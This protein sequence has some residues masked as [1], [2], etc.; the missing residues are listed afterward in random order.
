MTNII[1]EY[2]NV[3]ETKKI[4][5]KILARYQLLSEFTPVR[6]MPKTTQSFNM[7][8]VG[9]HRELNTIEAAADKN[10]KQEQL[11]KEKAELIAAVDAA[12]ATLEEDERYI[13]EENMVKLEKVPDVFIYTDLHMGKTEYYK[14][15]IKTIIKL[16]FCLGVEVYK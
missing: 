4:V 7:A 1:E 10:I 16:A 3:P 2:I 12:I 6:H 11:L 9:T 14:L 15:K 5:K 8:P 13:V